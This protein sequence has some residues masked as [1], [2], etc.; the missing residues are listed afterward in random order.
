MSY[1]ENGKKDMNNLLNLKKGLDFL[2]KVATIIISTQ[3][4]RV[5]KLINYYF[6]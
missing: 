3:D 4:I 1:F 2:K 6:T 5:L